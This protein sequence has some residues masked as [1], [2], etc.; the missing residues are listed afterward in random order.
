M[1]SLTRRDRLDCLDREEKLCVHSKS[2]LSWLIPVDYV[3]LRTS[4][5]E[6]RIT[7]LGELKEENTHKMF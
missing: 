2:M 7:F 6:D 1:R 5:S 3:L 4:H